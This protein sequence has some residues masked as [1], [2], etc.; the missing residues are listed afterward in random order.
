[1]TSKFKQSH[2]K[3]STLLKC[4]NPL[5]HVD[6]KYELKGWIRN[7]RSQG[8]ILFVE[9]Y[10]GSCS[11]TLQLI[12]DD[13]DEQKKD[14]RKQIDQYC[15]TGATIFVKGVIVKSPAK[16]QIIELLVDECQIYGKITDINNYLPLVKKI[17]LEKMREA[18]HLRS[19]FR[20]MQAIFKIRSKLMKI[21]HDFFHS[22]NV[23]HL[24]PNIV[25]TS[26][27]E[28]AG[29]VFTITNLIGKDDKINVEQVKDNKLD[30][31]EDFFR[32]RAYLTVSSQLGLEALCSGMGSVYTTNPS[33]RAEKSKTKRHLASFTHLEWEL[34]FID[35]NDLMNFSEDLVTTCFKR[36]LSECHDELSELDQFVSKGIIKKLESFLS[37]DF[38]RISYDEA[39]KLIIDNK[40][41]I[42]KKFKEVEE[43]PKWGDDLGSFCERYI[44][45]EIYKRPTFV[46][47]YPRDLKSFYMKQNESYKYVNSEK[48]E[49]KE[50]IR[51][52]VQGCDLLIPGLGE[53]I[54]SSIREDNYNLL[55]QEMERKNIDK[56]PLEWYLDLRKNGTFPHGGA[57]LGFDR[58]VNV[59]CLMEGNIRD[60]VPFPVSFEECDY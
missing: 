45:E 59:C 40:A 46:Y 11:K 48:G 7:S 52:T 56:K 21:V 31:K 33:F 55:V 16:G 58:L 38:A 54:G 6:Q 12:F 28:G 25:T 43:I 41:N 24:D 9:M 47:N 32:K 15:H 18:Y 10:D 2:T 37:N 51:H 17:S 35:L 42:M 26:D 27:C 19:K 13:K 1:M 23:H 49:T 29:E 57:G 5:I 14:L 60:V 53:L 36:V 34:A 39:I 44:C 8:D 20:S 50:E 30:F 22:N 3:I 4:D